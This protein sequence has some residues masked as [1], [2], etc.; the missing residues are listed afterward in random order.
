MNSVDI[1]EYNIRQIEVLL[2]SAGGVL[3]PS[4]IVDV[5]EKQLSIKEIDRAIDI[6]N[7][8]YTRVNSGFVIR[9]LAGGYKVCIKPEFSTIIKK[10]K[11]REKHEKLSR[12]ALE[13][14]AIVA[15]KQPITRVE[16]D[17]MRGVNSEGVIKGLL[18]KG[19]IRICGKKDVPGRPLLYATTQL[20][21]E[22][23]GL[24]S[25]DEL[26]KMEE[27]EAVIGEFDTQEV[28]LGLGEVALT[29]RESGSPDPSS[30][31]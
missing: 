3:S 21:L 18:E 15:Y 20:F 14:L 19:F 26:P 8:F 16:I 5:F 9:K 27:V 4:L 1:S 12:A 2:F 30:T 17:Q 13:V 24:N 28:D 23:F 29:N 25:I 6:L 10:L 31:K 7:D 22:S 11:Q